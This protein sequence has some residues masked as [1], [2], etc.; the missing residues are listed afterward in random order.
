M[1]RNRLETAATIEDL[2]RVARQ[3]IP[4]ITLGYLESG[5]GSELA[6]RR[7][8]EALDKVV[9]APRYIR[10]VSHRSATTSIFGRAHG[11]PVGISPVGLANAIWPGTDK[12]LA[13]ASGKANVPYGLSTVGTTSIEEIASIP[14][15]NLWFQLYAAQD[16]E[17]TFDLLDRAKLARVEVLQVTVDVPIQSRRVQDIRNGFQLPLRLGLGTAA[18]ILCHPTWVAA[19]LFSGM[20]RFESLAK[21]APRGAST[22]SLASYVA[23]HITDQLDAVL[24]RRIRDAWPGKLV[25]KGVMDRSTAQ[26]ALDVGADGIIVSNHGGRQFDAAA[27][28]IE[29]LPAI[30]DAF[31]DRLTVMMDGGV[32][33]GEDVLRAMALG[34]KF[35]FSGRSF[36]YGV[37]ASGAAG[38]AKVFEIFK[39]EILRGMA[40]LGITELAELSAIA[41][42]GPALTD[43]HELGIA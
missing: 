15:S 18:D 37:A 14:G 21:Y 32:R 20:P 12:M 13:T 43:E 39:D 28:P 36:V 6:L 25:I 11:L 31:G 5:T 30:A 17:I 4:K 7:N 42:R 38:A 33:S 1:R 35:V 16:S 41:T 10:D 27:A 22:P 24:L 19:C 23:G 26:L 34:A 2:A 40:Q 9:L 8:R 3:R 29:V